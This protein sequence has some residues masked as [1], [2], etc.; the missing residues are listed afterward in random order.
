MKEPCDFT[1]DLIDLTVF[2]MGGGDF[3]INVANFATL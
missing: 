2:N 1:Q 3:T